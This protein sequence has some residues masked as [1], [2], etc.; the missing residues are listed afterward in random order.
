[1]RM[2]PSTDRGVT[3]QLAAQM[4]ILYTAVRDAGPDK[5]ADIN[6]QS[7]DDFY[8]RNLDFDI[9]AKN[10]ERLRNILT[11]LDDLLGDGKRQGWQTTTQCTS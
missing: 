8:Y 1:M 10:I 11:K 7:I 2:K 3:R 9:N 6:A 4:A 5:L